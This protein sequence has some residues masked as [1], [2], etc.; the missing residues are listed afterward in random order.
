M[1]TIWQPALAV[2]LVVSGAVLFLG[3]VG[4][5]FLD[6]DSPLPDRPTAPDGSNND[7]LKE[8][9][10]GYHYSVISQSDWGKRRRQQLRAYQQTQDRGQLAKDLN[11]GVFQ[12]LR[13]DDRNRIRWS[14]NWIQWLLGQL[15]SP[16]A[17]PQLPAQITLRQAGLC[18][19]AATVLQNEL[20]IAGIPTRIVGLSGHVVLE[21]QEQER[22]KMLDP[23]Y[24]LA[25]DRSVADLARAA[26]EGSD[27]WRNLA[28]QL[29]QRGFSS[30]AIQ[31]YQTILG[32]P[33]DNQTLPVDAPINPRLTLMA[34]WTQWLSPLLAL[35]M[36]WLGARFLLKQVNRPAATPLVSSHEST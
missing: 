27:D 7:H 3:W 2:L 8:G 14:E 5:Q 20:Q 1:R 23:D 10:A 33:A 11:E 4:E 34:A 15:Y 18:S 6:T 9:V 25:T 19:E 30:K 28:E 12:L 31:D 17:R 22:W 16:A 32:S 26:A 35:V 21:Y 24:G 29:T 13:H 36:A